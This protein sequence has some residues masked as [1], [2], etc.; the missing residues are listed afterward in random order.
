MDQLIEFVGNHPLLTGG[1]AAVTALLIYTE[2]MRKVQG[3]R[4]LSP[5]QA[6][7]WI[8][9]PQAVVVDISPVADFNKGHIVNARNIPAS[10]L[11]DPDAETL[12]LRDKKLLLV[13][14]SGQ[15][16]SAA[17]ASCRKMGATE[18][19]VLKG[20]MTQWRSDQFPVT[21]K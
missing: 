3:V 11:A 17:A 7:A 12:K 5:V 18:V 21:K 9:D 1:F 20:G 6:V 16:A 13:C 14:K 19:A 4:E 8:N 2:I 10:R 15:S